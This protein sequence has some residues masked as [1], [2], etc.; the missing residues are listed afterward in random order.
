M[1]SQESDSLWMFNPL[2]FFLCKLVS[3]IDT[4]ATE[5]ATVSL[6]GVLVKAA[7]VELDDLVL[8]GCLNA[9]LFSSLARLLRNLLVDGRNASFQGRLDALFAH[10]EHLFILG[11]D[12][13]FTNRVVILGM[14]VQQ[15]TRIGISY[16]AHLC[17]D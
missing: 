15:R 5:P 13:S 11:H 16:N 6:Q 3:R 12:Y 10:V 9:A 8:A 17:L 4:I 7:R 14:V 1:M 2:S